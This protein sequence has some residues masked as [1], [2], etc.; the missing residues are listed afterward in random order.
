MLSLHDLA[1]ISED[2]YSPAQANGTRAAGLHGWRRFD[3]IHKNFF[4]SFYR[5]PVWG[6]FAIRGTSE[7]D[8]VGEDLVTWGLGMPL[9]SMTDAVGWCRAYMPYAPNMLVCGHSLGGAYSQYVGG[10][11][12]LQSITFNA[13]G[14]FT[15]VLS[16]L[17]MQ[18]RGKNHLNFRH[19]QDVVSKAGTT[20]GPQYDLDM[21]FTLNLAAAHSISNIAD[22]LQWTS[23]PPED[24]TGNTTFR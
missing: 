22:A 21:P 13:P 3:K 9:W 17:V 2:V 12:G 23:L 4:C 15:N 1:L 18:G 19:P 8:D 7:M 10:V 16:M 20:L 24:F 5:G 6:V 14:L 11:L